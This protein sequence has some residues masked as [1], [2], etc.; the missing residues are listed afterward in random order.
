M[1]KL[2]IYCLLIISTNKTIVVAQNN[3]NKDRDFNEFLSLFPKKTF[4]FFALWDFKNRTPFTVPLKSIPKNL[5]QQFICNYGIDSYTEYCPEKYFWGFSA[6]CR[7][8]DKDS[9]IILIATNDADAGCDEKWYLLSF[10]FEGKL[11][12]KLWI[13]GRSHLKLPK[14]E[15]SQKIFFLADGK[16][17]ENEIY[18]VIKKHEIQGKDETITQFNYKYNIKTNGLFIKVEGGERVE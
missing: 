8:P 9:C 13:F 2:I 11:I 3:E 14:N 1:R 10:T 16:I 7:F 15:T 6:L 18:L 17:Y 5:Y 4:P 12:D